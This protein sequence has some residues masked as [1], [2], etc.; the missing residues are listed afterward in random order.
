MFE[1][2]RIIVTIVF[3][4]SIAMTLVSAFVF[5]R[6]VLVL[7]FIIIQYCAWFWYTLSYIPYGRTM[8]CACFKKMTSKE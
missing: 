1:K 3:L 6:A 4:A 5:K 7:V 2:K 8:A